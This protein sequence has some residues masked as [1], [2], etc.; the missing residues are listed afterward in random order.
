VR[1]SRSWSIGVLVLVGALAS[2]RSF[3]QSYGTGDQELTIGAAAFRGLN[4]QAVFQ[5]DGYLYAP[6]SSPGGHLFY[7][8][9]HLPAGA[10]ITRFCA[11]LRNAE[12]APS[13]TLVGIQRVKLAPAGSPTGLLAGP[14]VNPSFNSG[15]AEF[16]EDVSYPVRDEADFDGDGIVD[17]LSHRVDVNMPEGATIG[18]GGVRI[19]WHRRVS[20]APDQ[21]SFADVPSDALFYPHVEALAASGITGGCGA[22]NYCPGAPLTRGQMA[23]FLAKALGL[24]WTQ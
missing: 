7:A 4:V 14:Y 10:F 16:C 2:A 11:S 12:P 24:N 6:G 8:P 23:V 15:Y 21:P 19:V 18:F 5:S 3:A 20:D 22:G 1:G 17:H 9:L 13:V